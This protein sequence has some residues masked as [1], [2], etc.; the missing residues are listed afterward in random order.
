M[1]FISGL[2]GNV[3]KHEGKFESARSLPSLGFWSGGYLSCS[4]TPHHFFLANKLIVAHPEYR[5]RP[6]CRWGR[7]C[8]ASY[9]S[10]AYGPFV[11]L[12]RIPSCGGLGML[13]GLFEF[14]CASREHFDFAAWPGKRYWPV[15][16]SHIPK[17]RFRQCMRVYVSPQRTY[18]L[19]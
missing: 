9:Y 17:L 14:Y 2:G 15:E 12:A 7:I 5:S 10:Y 16:A 19:L 4:A 8:W 13:P 1:G 3:C 18:Y 11:T 6:G